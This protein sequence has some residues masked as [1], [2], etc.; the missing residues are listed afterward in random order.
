MNQWF[1]SY[2]IYHENGGVFENFDF[3]GADVSQSAIDVIK[4]VSKKLA[5]EHGVRIDQI[6]FVSFNKV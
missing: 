6:M 5:E 1:M 3:Y 4:T 2:K